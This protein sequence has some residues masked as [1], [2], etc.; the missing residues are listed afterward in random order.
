MCRERP[1]PA[2]A[3]CLSQAASW[4]LVA[5]FIQGSG[6]LVQ[7]VAIEQADGDHSFMQITPEKP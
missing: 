7:R 2:T 4:S 5:C 1:G 3:F 6:A